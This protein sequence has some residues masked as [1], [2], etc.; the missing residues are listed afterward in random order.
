MKENF[1]IDCKFHY[2]KILSLI[3]MNIQLKFLYAR[4]NEHTIPMYI[5]DTCQNYRNNKLSIK[6]RKGDL[7]ISEVTGR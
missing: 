6:D 3:I 4:D 2:K 1:K 7:L 5:R